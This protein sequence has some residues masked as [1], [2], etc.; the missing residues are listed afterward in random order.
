[1]M[2][3][4]FVLALLHLCVSARSDTNLN[5]EIITR[6]S[7]LREKVN[8]IPNATVKAPTGRKIKSHHECECLGVIK[9][10]LG[11]LLDNV[12]VQNEDEHYILELKGNLNTLGNHKENYK[13]LMKTERDPR[14]AFQLYINF[15]RRLNTRA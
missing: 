8:L 3:Y 14:K 9:K 6:L 1:M 2:K 4:V 15:F 12:I 5:K 13:C 7:E 10:E 11:N